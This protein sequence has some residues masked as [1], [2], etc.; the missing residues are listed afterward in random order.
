MKKGNIIASRS[1]MTPNV[2]SKGETLR[3][4]FSYTFS[5]SIIKDL[6]ERRGF[7]QV[8]NAMRLDTAG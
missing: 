6:V 7:N 1:Q 3:V 2:G 8:V 4:S 5:V